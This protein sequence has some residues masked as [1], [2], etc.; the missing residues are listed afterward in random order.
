MYEFPKHFFVNLPLAILL[1]LKC[2]NE[3][4]VSSMITCDFLVALAS[5]KHRIPGKHPKYDSPV[6]KMSL[7]YCANNSF[8]NEYLYVFREKHSPNFSHAGVVPFHL[9]VLHDLQNG[10]H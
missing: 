3:D 5:Y 7:R 2:E 9:T 6:S 8:N 10:T 4:H 1:S